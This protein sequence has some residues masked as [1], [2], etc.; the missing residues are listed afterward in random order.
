VS[1]LTLGLNTDLYS[2]GVWGYSPGVNWP[3]REVNYLSVC[4]AEIKNEWSWNSAAC[5]SRHGVHKE[6]LPSLLARKSHT[7]KTNIFDPVF[8]LIQTMVILGLYIV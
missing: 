2:M 3:G 4:S 7:Q 1:K 5:I 8:R 6:P